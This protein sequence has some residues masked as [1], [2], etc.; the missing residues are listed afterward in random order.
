MNSD[1]TMKLKRKIGQF[2]LLT[3]LPAFVCCTKQDDEPVEMQDS[4]NW[5]TIVEDNITVEVPE[6]WTLRRLPATDSY[7]G[8]LT[9]KK[10]SLIFD[11]GEY[12]NNLDVDTTL[13]KVHFEM[14]DGKAAKII[15]SNLPGETHFGMH[16]DSVR[17][18]FMGKVGF[19]IEQTSAIPMEESKV[20]RI[21]RS[22]RF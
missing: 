16:I 1:L 18:S 22:F 7:Y 19:T 8:L 11:Y 10:D 9:N 13:Y 5:K 3:A 6:N 14:I 20:L 21:F 15:K 17:T 2:C 4:A 12:S